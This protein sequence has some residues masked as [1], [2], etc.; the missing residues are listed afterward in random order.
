MNRY[1]AIASAKANAYAEISEMIYG[2]IVNSNAKL[3]KSKTVDGKYASDFK[4][5]SVSTIAGMINVKFINK[6]FITNGKI[7]QAGESLG[8]AEVVAKPI[9]N[10]RLYLYILDSQE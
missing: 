2:S 7:N 4:M 9:C 8:Y 5:E 1:D 10:K 3:I 6:K